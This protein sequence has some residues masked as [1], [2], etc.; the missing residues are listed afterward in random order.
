MSSRVIVCKLGRLGE[1]RKI[2][3][4]TTPNPIKLNPDVTDSDRADSSRKRR[5][6]PDGRSGSVAA[7]G[8]D[9]RLLR[10]LMGTSAYEDPSRF[11]G[12]ESVSPARMTEEEEAMSM[13]PRGER[14]KPRETQVLNADGGLLLDEGLKK[15]IVSLKVGDTVRR[16]WGF[17]IIIGT[18][19][20][21]YRCVSF[22]V[23][24][25]DCYR[26]SSCAIKCRL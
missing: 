25:I 15:T 7:P 10:L 21:G 23:S 20:W 6:L 18:L 4:R 13:G 2:L 11:D 1:L 22:D 9:S 3:D 5:R 17:Y 24:R 16:P 8:S 14:E 19:Y 12:F 26:F